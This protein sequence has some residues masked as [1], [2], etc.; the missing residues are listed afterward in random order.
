[1]FSIRF[2]SICFNYFL[3]LL[4]SGCSRMRLKLNLMDDDNELLHNAWKKRSVVVSSFHAL[5]PRD[6]IAIQPGRKERSLAQ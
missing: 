6:R 2:L 1:M 5:S 3:N 4:V